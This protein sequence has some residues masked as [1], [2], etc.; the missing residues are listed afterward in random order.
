MLAEYNIRLAELK[1]YVLLSVSLYVHK[2]NCHIP[3]SIE[4]D[5]ASDRQ[6][7][8]SHVFRDRTRKTIILEASLV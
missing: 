2:T 5:L 4:Y 6:I 8:P 1:W 7:Y 3:E